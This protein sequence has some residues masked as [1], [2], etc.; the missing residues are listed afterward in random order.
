MFG[1]NISFEQRAEFLLNNVCPL[2][3]KFHLKNTEVANAELIQGFVDLRELL[4]DIYKDKDSYR[5]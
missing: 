2:P 3:E 5:G 4:I 1:E